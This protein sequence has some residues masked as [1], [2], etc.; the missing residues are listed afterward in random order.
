[1]FKVIGQ[2]ILEASIGGINMG[3]ESVEVT[4]IIERDGYT[5]SITEYKTKYT[6]VTRTKIRYIKFG[7]PE[8]PWRGKARVGDRVQFCEQYP[9]G[10]IESKE[11]LR[12]VVTEVIVSK[13]VEGGPRNIQRY[14]DVYYRIHL[15][16]Q[17]IEKPGKVYKPSWVWQVI[18]EDK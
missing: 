14:Q 16:K 17:P 6:L 5:I 18:K 4:T 10:C 11:G 8:K 13:K 3:K 2:P 12:G 7:L 15:D 9:D 1:M